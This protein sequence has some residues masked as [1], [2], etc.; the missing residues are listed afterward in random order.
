[1]AHEKKK[2]KKEERNFGN[3][4]LLL[5][6]S[7]FTHSQV[8]A[9]R[10]DWTLK[11]VKTQINQQIRKNPIFAS[12]SPKY[13]FSASFQKLTAAVIIDQF[14]LERYQKEAIFDKLQ[15]KCKF[16]KYFVWRGQS[17]LAGACA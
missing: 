5:L 9:K 10:L 2:K 14:E 15:S 3:S 1:M 11:W 8:I 6:L 7:S 17:Q 12:N 16:Q 13:W 4:S